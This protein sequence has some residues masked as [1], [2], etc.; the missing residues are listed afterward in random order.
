MPCDS[1]SS[2]TGPG[3]RSNWRTHN[4]V[5]I[6]KSLNARE[7]EVMAFVRWPHEQADRR[8]IGLGRG[9][10]KLHRGSL[11]RK[12]NAR[13]VAELA[14][15]AQILLIAR[16]KSLNLYAGMVSSS[17]RTM[18]L[19]RGCAELPCPIA[20]PP[21]EEQLCRRSILPSSRTTT[22]YAE[23]RNISCG[24]SATPQTR[25]NPPRTS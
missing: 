21:P 6:S 20:H 11:M 25:S 12:M 9:Q 23:R 1:R 8:P 19:L 2:G 15:M 22:P 4:C 13:S 16:P 7:R 14:R 3:V 10:V 5:R 18:Y 17:P 24:C